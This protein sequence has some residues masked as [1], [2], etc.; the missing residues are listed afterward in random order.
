MSQIA[1]PA[2]ESQTDD[3]LARAAGIADI[4]RADA[5]LAERQ[6]TLPATS[7]DALRGAHLFA[8]K[9]PREVG[10]FEADLA[11]QLAVFEAVSYLNPSAGWSL[12][13]GAAGLGLAAAFLPQETLPEIFAA[14]PC[15]TFTSGG[16]YVPGKLTPVDGGYMLSGKWIYGSGIRHADW[17]AVPARIEG[18]PDMITC[19]V[20]TR[21]FV[22]H[23]NWNVV[24]LQGSGSED[25]SVESVF[26][27]H[28]FTYTRMQGQKRGGDLYRLGLL[29]FVTVEIV[30]FVLGVARRALDEFVAV[31]R[32]KSRGYGDMV[33]MKAQPV[34]QSEIAA[35]DMKLKAARALNLAVYARAMAAVTGGRH[36][37][38]ELEVELRAA[39][40]FAAEAAL[41]VV[42]RAFR[43]SGSSAIRM[44]GVLQR[45]MRDVQAAGTHFIF[46]HACY[47]L[48]G[49]NLLASPGMEA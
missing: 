49:A 10:G 17:S 37:S 48:H 40:L 34:L 5:E 29:G 25:Y 16:G 20:P 32:S 36:L 39:G 26:V 23:D 24:G 31:T 12:F 18:S 2:S 47:E 35:L 14:N 28:R 33:A 8:L 7:V 4:L 46:T 21:E 1:F 45:C 11:T 38:P 44:S 27:P 43:F 6:R 41:E 22:L 15:P 3:L 19:V 42:N 13:I 30:G 9:A